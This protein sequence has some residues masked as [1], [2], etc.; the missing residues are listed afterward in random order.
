M[1]WLIWR[2]AIDTIGSDVY[3]GISFFIED[4]VEEKR[5]DRYWENRIEYTV[6][7]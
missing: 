5:S 2:R 3:D 7:Q 6:S 4:V 1:S